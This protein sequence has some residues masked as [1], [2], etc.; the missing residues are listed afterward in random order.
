MGRETVATVNWRGATAET[1]LLLEAG[2]PILRGA[3]KARIP[4]SDIAAVGRTQE[5]LALSVGGTPL[6]I[7]MAG[8]EANQWIK[9]LTKPP[10]DLRTKL[11]IGP[12]KPAYILGNVGDKALAA[13]LADAT[14]ETTAD[15]ATILAVLGS[16][17]DLEAALT[18][19]RASPARP[20]WCV[21]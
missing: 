5:G 1:K 3:V 9:A 10:P 6:N 7:A 20:L 8:P 15:A 21:Y 16:H 13:A 18:V 12:Q 11:D 2:E 17:A 4:R 19:A 14:T